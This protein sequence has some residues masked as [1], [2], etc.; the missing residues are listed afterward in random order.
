MKTITIVLIA[1]LT[2]LGAVLSGCEEQYAPPT[3]TDFSDKVAIASSVKIIQRGDFTSFADLSKGVTKR[4]WTIPESASIINLNGRDTSDLP[5]VH[6]QFNEPGSFQVNL[7][8]D[9]LLEALHLDTNF[10]VTVYDYVVSKIEVVSIEASYSQQSQQQIT[11]SK[12]G[13]VTFNDA[14]TG[15]PNRR[16]WEFSGGLPSSAGGIDAVADAKVAQVKVVYP[17]SGLFDVKLVAWRRLPNSEPDT[18]LLKDFVKVIENL[19]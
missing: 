12:G 16:K 6:V 5:L 8:C 7:K 13:A 15:N 14:S 17:E 3:S 11:I 9:Y 4:T 10:I 1:G 19:P 18:L 2:I